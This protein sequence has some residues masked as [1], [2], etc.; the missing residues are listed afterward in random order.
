MKKTIL[1]MLGKVTRKKIIYLHKSTHS[2][3]LHGVI[4][5]LTVHRQSNKT[6]SAKH[7]KPPYELL[8]VDF[9]KCHLNH[10]SC[11]N[12]PWLPPRT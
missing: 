7:G 11:S 9:Q 5:F 3:I 10:A 8:A 2:V 6:P 4:F 1:K 12:C